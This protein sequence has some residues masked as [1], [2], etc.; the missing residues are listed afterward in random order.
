MELSVASE[1]AKTELHKSRI[2]ALEAEKYDIRIARAGAITDVENVRCYP[3]GSTDNSI[4]ACRR[5]K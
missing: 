5:G 1:K 3:C 2:D 4:F